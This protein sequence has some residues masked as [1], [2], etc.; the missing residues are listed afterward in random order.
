MHCHSTKTEI[1]WGRRRGT[2]NGSW[3]GQTMV[4]VT[5]SS[6]IFE[7]NGNC[8]T[9]FLELSPAP[10]SIPPPSPGDAPHV[11]TFLWHLLPC[12]S[13][14]E[15]FNYSS[16]E[17]MLLPLHTSPHRISGQTDLG[18]NPIQTYHSLAS[19]PWASYLTSLLSKNAHNHLCVIALLW[20]VKNECKVPYTVPAQRGAQ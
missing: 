4:S 2:G 20:G 19:W 13:P 5:L 18:S 16:L 14:L 11:S 9:S 12:W 7:K 10:T 6:S 8:L 17:T 1:P 3:I 15:F